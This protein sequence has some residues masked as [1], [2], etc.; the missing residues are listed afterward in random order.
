MKYT[1]DPERLIDITAPLSEDTPAWPG[2][3]AFRRNVREEYGFSTS[4]IVMSAH[5]GTHMDAPA[6]RFSGGMTID[7]IPASRMIMPCSVLD[8][9]RSPE[10]RTE[11][12]E[13]VDLHGRAV[14][15]KTGVRGHLSAGAAELLLEKGALLVGIDSMSVDAAQC[16]D[17]HR[18]LLGA[19]IPILE[20]LLL[21]G[22]EP[23]DY[24]LLCIPLRI[25]SGDGSPCRVFL[26][27]LIT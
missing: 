20:N 13:R 3:T 7:L 17:V 15:F 23:G 12:L 19:E 6:H 16:D 14:V 2:D 10:V 8:L 11:E 1:I 5:S 9:T 26:Q 25:V 22:V 24:I 4:R 21:K 27:P 18:T